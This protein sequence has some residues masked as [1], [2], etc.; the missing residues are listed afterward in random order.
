[1][2]RTEQATQ[3]LIRAMDKGDDLEAVWRRFTDSKSV[4]YAAAGDALLWARNELH[5]A[6]AEF[7]VTRDQLADERKH[8]ESILRE[9]DAAREEC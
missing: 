3:E 7:R 5:S 2:S 8:L 9:R 4:L 1:M 6:L